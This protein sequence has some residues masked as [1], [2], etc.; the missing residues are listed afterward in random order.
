V[1]QK[2]QPTIPLPLILILL[3]IGFGCSGPR[4][5]SDTDRLFKVNSA[6]IAEF[7]ERTFRGRGPGNPNR[8]PP[9]ENFVLAVGI[10]DG[11]CKANAGD[12]IFLAYKMEEND[13]F[14]DCI[15][16]VEGGRITKILKINI[17]NETPPNKMIDYLLE[18]NCK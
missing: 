15:L 1:T 7:V 2:S 17:D 11:P 3:F 9:Q 18:P 10:K 16:R 8:I 12:I 6:K 13:H 4:K 14:W 5:Q